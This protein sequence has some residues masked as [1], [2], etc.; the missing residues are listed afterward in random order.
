MV[1]RY[2]VINRLKR[3]LLIRQMYGDYTKKSRYHQVTK[4]YNFIKIASGEDAQ[5][6]LHLMKIKNNKI[7]EV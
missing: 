4:K 6:S 2:V 1:P 7:V 3:P 5:T